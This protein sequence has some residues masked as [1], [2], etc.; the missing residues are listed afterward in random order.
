[1]A[2]KDRTPAP[3]RNTP[4]II[5]LGPGSTQLDLSWLPEDQLQALLGDY[6]KKVLDIQAKAI[7]LG[8][9][10][11]VLRTTL[12][13]LSK[14]A[15]EVAGHGNSVT[16]EHEQKTQTGRTTA[17]IGNTQKAAK[18]ALSFGVDPRML[19]IVGAIVIAAVVIIA[20]LR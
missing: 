20:L 8:I 6:A 1:M 15:T 7:E 4:T 12:D 13:T 3:I 14:T 9:E 2:D 17:I 16:L 10:A 11:T 18:G 19:Y 5:N